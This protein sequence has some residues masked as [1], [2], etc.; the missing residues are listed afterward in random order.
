MGRGQISLLTALVFVIATVSVATESARN[1]TVVQ[2]MALMQQAD[3]NL[4]LL[5]GMTTGRVFFDRDNAEQAR[6]DLI[7]V[8]DQIPKR[9]RRARTDTMSHADPRIWDNW[10]DFRSHAKAAETAA[11]RIRTSNLDR[12]TRTMP[13][14]IDACLTCH[15]N[16]RLPK[17]SLGRTYSPQ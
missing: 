5:I 6:K 4:D 17:D 10:K 7:R 11:K 1:R 8:I 3:S 2:R 12:L 14:V 15:R 13:P 16:Y 9:F